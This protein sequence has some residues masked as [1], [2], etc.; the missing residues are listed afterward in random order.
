[1]ARQHYYLGNSLYKQG[2]IAEAKKEWQEALRITRDLEMKGYIREVERR[3][4]EEEWESEKRIAAEQAAFK[5]MDARKDYQGKLKQKAKEQKAKAQK[6]PVQKAQT[7][8]ASVE[9]TQPQKP[10]VQKAQPQKSKEEQIKKAAAVPVTA[11]DKRRAVLERKAKELRQK[12]KLAQ[13][14]NKQKEKARLEAQKKRQDKLA[15]KAELVKKK[16]EDKRQKAIQQELA[17]QAKKSKK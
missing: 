2:K 11:E 4:K 1:V 12:Q 7:Q 17:R 13:F 15:R 16:E 9:K 14:K 6:P 3:S 10:P 5:R 8:K